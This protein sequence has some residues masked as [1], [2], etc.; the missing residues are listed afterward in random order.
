MVL[1]NIA[2]A[3][4]LNPENSNKKEPTLPTMKK[5]IS[6]MIGEKITGRSIGRL[7]T[8]LIAING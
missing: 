4:L 8:C 7:V 3:S 1:K 2:I 5:A 6:P